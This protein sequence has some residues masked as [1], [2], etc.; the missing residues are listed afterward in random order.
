[1]SDA[2]ATHRKGGRRRQARATLAQVEQLGKEG[3][4]FGR[5]FVVERLGAGGMGVVIAAY[6]PDLDRKVAIKVLRPDGVLVRT[7]LR[8]QMIREAQAMARLAHPN[9]VAVHEVGTVERA[10]F[11]VMELVEGGTLKQWMKSPHPWRD[12]VHTLVEAGRGLAAAH[13]HGLVHRD[14][15]PHNVLVGKDGRVRVTDFGVVGVAGTSDG[16]AVGTP[17]YMAPEQRTPDVVDAR[18]DQ[19]A[20]CATLWEAL[21]GVPPFLEELAVHAG[22]PEQ[23]SSSDVPARIHAVIARG[24]AASPDARFASM[25]ELLAALQYDPRRKWRAAMIGALVLVLAGVAVLGW[26]RTQPVVADTDPCRTTAPTLDAAWNPTTRAS[27]AGAFGVTAPSLGAE[28]LARI[29]PRL[30]TYAAA[31]AT[32]RGRVCAAQSTAAIAC[33][34][35]RREH[36]A[37]LTHVLAHASERPI[38]ENAVAAVASLEPPRECATITQR[39]PTLGPAPDLGPLRARLDQARSYLDAGLAPKAVEVA[40]DA[41][42]RAESP[43]AEAHAALLLGRALREVTDGAGAREA[44]VRAVRT[45]SIAGLDDVVARAYT[46]LA[47]VTSYIEGKPAETLAM[48]TFVEAAVARAGS[49]A[50]LRAASE[51]AVGAALVEL[52]RYPEARPHLDAAEKIWRTE[53]DPTHPEAARVL[54]TVGNVRSYEGDL[55]GAE[56]AYR[57]VVELR[58]SNLGPHHPGLAGPLTNLGGLLL[59]RGDADAAKQLCARSLDILDLSA[60]A[61]TSGRINALRCLGRASQTLEPLEKAVALAERGP[62]G[63]GAYALVDLGEVAFAKGD[64]VRSKEACAR[65]LANFTGELA[66]HPDRS[67]PLRCLGRVALAARDAAH[68]RDLLEQALALLGDGGKTA[69]RAELRYLLAQAL[70]M[71]DVDPAQQRELAT[72]AAADFAGIGASARAAEIEAWL[73][74]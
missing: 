30:D 65:A 35:R 74:G 23:P 37:A 44:L 52:G 64:P 47:W 9:V 2:D 29:A 1:M 18:A 60:S 41:L 11:I 66:K 5:F 45:A 56:A 10:F 33:L 69:H 59:E 26:S 51:Y 32:E 14:F 58:E 36:F 19:F 24:L 55:A 73:R 3:E 7:E 53:L 22:P 25:E 49:P 12:V 39:A 4:R 16:L 17:V 6:D 42:A 54:L 68:A 38:V 34:E 48:A 61:V 27:T 70:R 40:R 72:Q 8:E 28:T 67:L 57:K 63:Q 15:K 62:N 13:A 50:Q 21:Y 20:F 43:E 31:W 46:E 71:L